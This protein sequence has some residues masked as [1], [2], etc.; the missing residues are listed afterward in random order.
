M[1][2]FGT[3]KK[4]QWGNIVIF[5][6]DDLVCGFGCRRDCNKIFYD[7]WL[8]NIDKYCEFR[9][10]DKPTGLYQ[11]TDMDCAL[12]VNFLE[13]DRKRKRRS[14][15]PVLKLKRLDAVESSLKSLQKIMLIL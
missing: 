1:T 8:D 6:N 14:P 7:Y 2:F 11:Y 3:I 15:S 5:N 10:I 12:V 13:D 4:D 9:K